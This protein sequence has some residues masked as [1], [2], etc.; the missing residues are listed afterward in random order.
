MI[1]FA[2]SLEFTTYACDGQSSWHED[3]IIEAESFYKAVEELEIRLDDYSEYET[4]LEISAILTAPNGKEIWV[5]L[6]SGIFGRR[7]VEFDE[8]DVIAAGFEV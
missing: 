3:E 2:A 1:R 8:E 7:E 4:R 5:G 6:D